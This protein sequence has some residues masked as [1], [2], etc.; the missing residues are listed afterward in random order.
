[1]YF[2]M[3]DREATVHDSVYIKGGG[4]REEISVYKG[5]CNPSH[6]KT[7]MHLLLLLRLGQVWDTLP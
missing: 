6:L 3:S 2:F 4:G 5:P 1:M 7:P